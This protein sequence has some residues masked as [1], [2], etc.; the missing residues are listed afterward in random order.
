M[1]DKQAEVT[2]LMECF[3]MYTDRFS[4]LKWDEAYFLNP[5]KYFSSVVSVSTVLACKSI[6][7]FCLIS[8]SIYVQNNYV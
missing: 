3:E 7:L 5:E 2:R 6:N 4:R 8:L 1:Q